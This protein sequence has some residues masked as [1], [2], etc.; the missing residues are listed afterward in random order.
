M[1]VSF[2][3]DCG[4]NQEYVFLNNITLV[5]F[6]KFFLHLTVDGFKNKLSYSLKRV[7]SLEIK[8]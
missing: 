5:Q 4:F 2:T 6:T 8:Q 1:K 7:N 3:Y